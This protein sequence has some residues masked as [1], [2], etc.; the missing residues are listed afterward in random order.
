MDKNSPSIFHLTIPPWIP[1]E[2]PGS[3]FSGMESVVFGLQF[4]KKELYYRFQSGHLRK[5]VGVLVMLQT[6]DFLKFPEE[7]LFGTHQCK[8]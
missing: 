1:P 5:L 6:V 8:W 4:N 7:L 3:H 2:G